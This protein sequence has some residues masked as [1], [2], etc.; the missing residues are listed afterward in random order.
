LSRESYLLLSYEEKTGTWRAVWLFGVAYL[1]VEKF[2]YI[3]T[4]SF[5][6]FYLCEDY[7]NHIQSFKQLK[8]PLLWK[9]NQINQASVCDQ[10]VT[11]YAN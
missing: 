2:T 9:K 8:L 1:Q 6:I 10:F 4:A 5:K 3:L 7:V 11:N